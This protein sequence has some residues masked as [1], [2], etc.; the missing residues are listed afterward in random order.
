MET[1]T[2]PKQVGWGLLIKSIMMIGLLIGLIVFKT[3]D[4]NDWFEV[5]KFFELIALA[6]FVIMCYDYLQFW[7][8]PIATVVIYCLTFG[9]YDFYLAWLQGWST[10]VLK[11][12]FFNHLV[13]MYPILWLFVLVV[14]L[15]IPRK[16]HLAVFKTLKPFVKGE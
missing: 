14:Y 15:I 5:F 6:L 2:F 10:E 12:A 13:L 7:T 3:V 11:V 1:F 9:A 8:L 4:P 16:W